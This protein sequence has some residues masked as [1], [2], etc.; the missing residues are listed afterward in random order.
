MFLLGSFFWR[1]A[2]FRYSPSEHM[3]SLLNGRGCILAEAE[4]IF[5]TF[6]RSFTP[7]LRRPHFYLYPLV[8]CPGLFPVN[9]WECWFVFLLE[10]YIPNARVHLT[11]R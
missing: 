10:A 3:A 5:A 1:M 2:I 6:H 4:I 7:L 8:P 11:N 9:G